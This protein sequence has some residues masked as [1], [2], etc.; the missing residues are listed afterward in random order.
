MPGALFAQT[1]EP[2]LGRSSGP[3]LMRVVFGLVI[4]IGLIYACAWVARRA[5]VGRAAHGGVPMKVVGT[6]ALGPRERILT[7]EVEDTWLIVGLTPG[8][9]HTLHT[10]PARPM[11]AAPAG[12][13]M[14]GLEQALRKHAAEP[15]QP[16]HRSPS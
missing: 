7:V 14:S 1:L 5:G 6:L 13:F 10:L 11:P 15:A 16:T 12:S 8:G 3:V 2:T 4:V 9:M